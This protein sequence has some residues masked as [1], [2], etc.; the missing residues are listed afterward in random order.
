MSSGTE[1]SRTGRVALVLLPLTTYTLLLCAGVL[2][3]TSLVSNR[4]RVVL[5]L[6]G[7][8]QVGLLISW[9]VTTDCIGTWCAERGGVGS[10]L[11]GPVL[12]GAALAVAVAE[13]VRHAQRGAP[14][15]A[16]SRR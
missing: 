10:W 9:T 14:G 2:S 13:A 7:G 5:A 15:A 4:T 3:L 16:T 12:I 8:V 6:A 11:I 1:G